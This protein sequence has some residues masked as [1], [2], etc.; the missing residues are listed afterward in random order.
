MLKASVQHL[1]LDPLKTPELFTDRLPPL[2]SFHSWKCGQRAF[3]PLFR[4]KRCF[5]LESVIIREQRTGGDFPILPQSEPL[6][7]RLSHFSHHSFC[8]S[9]I[10]HLSTDTGHL[11]LPD[12]RIDRQTDPGLQRSPRQIQCEDEEI[13]GQEY[14]W[15][16]CFHWN[17]KRNLI[18]MCQSVRSGG[19]GGAAEAVI[20]V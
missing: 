19:G 16:R 2:G 17:L 9:G 8:P 15:N 10:S 18:K 4:T 20:K 6:V 11:Q 12:R 5:L 13:R 14:I 7:F 3:W 1:D